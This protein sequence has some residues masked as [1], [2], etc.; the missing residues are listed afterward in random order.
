MIRCSDSPA[1]RGGKTPN[2]ANDVLLAHQGAPR[3]ALHANHLLLAYHRCPDLRRIPDP[4][5]LPQLS[6]HPLEPAGVPARTG[7][8]SAA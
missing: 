6:Q 1:F 3:A 5:L 8:N 2:Q 7:P 4:E